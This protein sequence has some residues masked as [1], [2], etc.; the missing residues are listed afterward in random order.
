M[1]GV[2]SPLKTFVGLLD[3]S[4]QEIAALATD[5]RRF[6]P[7]RIGRI[8]DIWDNNTFSL[9]S[10]A[11]A[12]RPFRHWQARAGLRWM[13]DS[14]SPGERCWSSWTRPSTMTCP[15]ARP[16]SRSTGI[17]KAGSIRGISH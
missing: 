7:S 17:T 15:P 3:R 13:G 5:A 6:D 8:A 9:V 12:P 16:N 1:R 4:I 11:C 2:S 14:G 10:G